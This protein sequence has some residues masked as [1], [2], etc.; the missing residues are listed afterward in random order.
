MT[1]VQSPLGSLSTVSCQNK[2]FVPCTYTQTQKE[3]ESNVFN[4]L[5]LLKA[6]ATPGNSNLNVYLYVAADAR[7]KTKR[8]YKTQPA[9]LLMTIHRT[10]LLIYFLH[11]S[12]LFSSKILKT[13]LLVSFKYETFT[14]SPV[15]K[16][17]SLMTTHRKYRVHSRHY[18]F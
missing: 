17:T 18:P 9:L 14:Y 8:N 15:M 16:I 11:F 3:T 6:W 13:Y 10:L 7:T 12:K 5:P 2:D 4:L 1:S